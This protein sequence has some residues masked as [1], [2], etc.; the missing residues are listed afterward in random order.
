[1]TDSEHQSLSKGE[2]SERREQSAWVRDTDLS[3][4]INEQLV[5]VRR[6]YTMRIRS[7]V[8]AHFATFDCVDG[9]HLPYLL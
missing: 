1:M 4:K 6:I 8:L 9:H 7:N 3:K 2:Q 5:K